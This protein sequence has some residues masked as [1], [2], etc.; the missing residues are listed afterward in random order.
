MLPAGCSGRLPLRYPRA[1][2]DAPPHRWPAVIHLGLKATLYTVP[3]WVESGGPSGLRCAISQR[4]IVLP[5][6]RVRIRPSWLNTRLLDGVIP[7]ASGGPSARWRRTSHSRSVPSSAVAAS[8]APSGLSA[9][10]ST[11][12]DGP[13]SGAPSGC[14]V[15]TFQSWIV[16]SFRPGAASIVPLRLKAMA[17]TSPGVIGQRRAAWIRAA[18]VPEPDA[19]IPTAR[20]E[21]TSPCRRMPPPGSGP[22]GRVSGAPYAVQPPPALALRQIRIV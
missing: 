20:R 17:P 10:C 15:A 5:L 2:P 8:V 14:L 16:A 12:P 21:Q 7:V 19:A 1:G 22:A 3:S 13:V 6:A 4:I 11:A 18:Q 9:S